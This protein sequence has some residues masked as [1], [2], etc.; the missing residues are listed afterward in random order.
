MK[1]VGQKRRKENLK[2][3]PEFKILRQRLKEAVK[4]KSAGK[5]KNSDFDKLVNEL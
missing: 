5:Y 2:P 1:I 3:T 4:L